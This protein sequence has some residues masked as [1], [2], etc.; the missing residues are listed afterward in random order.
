MV[1]DAVQVVSDTR[2]DLVGF[3]SP[4]HNDH[5]FCF[6]QFVVALRVRMSIFQVVN[7][8]VLLVQTCFLR[9]PGTEEL[10]EAK[11]LTM[12]LEVNF[13]LVDINVLQ[14]ALN[15]SDVRFVKEIVLHEMHF[16][17]G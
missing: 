3:Q 10:V 14:I 16:V 8:L 5:S 6:K 15:Y 13:H 7:I 9:T 4:T 11:W 2:S 12:A 17:T 1:I